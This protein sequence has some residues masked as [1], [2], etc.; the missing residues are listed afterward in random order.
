[1]EQVDRVR[2]C[3]VIAVNN[4]YRC[5]PWADY[6]YACDYR[7]WLYH[8]ESLRSVFR[9]RLITIDQEAAGKYGLEFVPGLP[10]AGLGV[11]AIHHGSNSG[12]Q[13]INLAY[14]F[15]ARRVLLLGYDMQKHA[16]KSHFFGDHPP[17]LVQDS[18]Y[19][20]FIKAFD[21]IDPAD[22]GMEIINCT[23]GSALKRF[24]AVT[25]DAALCQND[26]PAN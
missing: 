20:Q 3:N 7:W 11:N 1:M 26:K 22:Y 5:A 21:T 17:G 19:R 14:M 23:P 4:A 18:P 9:G 10:R 25:L 8:H 2:Y 24:P 16:G 13:A 15:G 12:Y 6:L